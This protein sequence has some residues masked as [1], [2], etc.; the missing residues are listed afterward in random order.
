MLE[1]LYELFAARKIGRDGHVRLS[2]AEMTR[3]SAIEEALPEDALRW[4][5]G[6]ALRD[7]ARRLASISEIPAVA[8][9]LGLK[10]NLRHYQ[11]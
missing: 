11:E 5:G 1:A 2:R 3:L 9:P 8:A 6:A 10:A 7:M 4:N